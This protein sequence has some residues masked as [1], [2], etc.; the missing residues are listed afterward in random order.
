MR[1]QYPDKIKSFIKENGGQGSARNMGI[2]KAVGEYISFVDSDDWLDLDTLEKMYF[3]AKKDK[4]DIVICDMVDHYSYYT[5]SVSYTHLR[6]H[7]T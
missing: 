1:C 2:E 6:A 5:I 7:E 4:S 3:L